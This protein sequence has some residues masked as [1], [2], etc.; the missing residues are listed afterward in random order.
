M[1]VSKSGQTPTE[2]DYYLGSEY[3]GNYVWGLAMNL[4]W[5]ELNEN[6]LHEKL[7]L[8]TEDKVALEMADKF[9]HA[10]FTKND[11][12]EKSYYLKSGYGQ[13]TIDLINKESRA[14]FPGKSFED[15]NVRLNERDIISY[16]YFLKE[17][18]YLTRFTEKD[19]SFEKEK[20]KGF[21]ARN[22][23]QRENIGILKY[24]DDDRFIINLKLKD[25]GDEL[26]LAK[27]FAREDPEEALTKINTYKRERPSWMS[28][29]DQFAMPKL[30]LNHRRDYIRLT[31]K[32]LANE[33]FEK[34][35][36]AQ[37]FENI[38]FDM[39]HKGARVEN[40]AG[41]VV[42][43]GWGGQKPKIK[44]F[45]LDKPF[46]VLMKR[47]NSQLPYFVLGVQNSELMEKVNY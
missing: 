10:P 34:Y 15:L 7:K 17:V 24:W 25:D 11:L 19:V 43:A 40:E 45:I 8:K 14:K 31:G 20:V 22:L 2:Q 41:I 27:G 37:M 3:K 9:N 33:G 5:N 42:G 36:L 46:W 30:H 26:I 13:R 18:E 47:K 38:K 32:F 12:D 21:Y 29:D 1:L 16:A 35:F 23:E 4:A 6:I 28:N 44:K 39:D